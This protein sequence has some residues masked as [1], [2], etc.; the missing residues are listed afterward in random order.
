MTDT[1]LLDSY[2]E[3]PGGQPIK[4][5]GK[6]NSTKGELVIETTLA[7]SR[8]S[9]SSPPATGADKVKAYKS[10]RTRVEQF[11]FPSPAGLPGIRFLMPPAV[12]AS[13][14]GPSQA[15]STG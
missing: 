9:K 13:W 5:D 4:Y 2:T 10:I 6:D 11:L 15:R 3:Q 7:V 14:S 12:G 8:N 1:T